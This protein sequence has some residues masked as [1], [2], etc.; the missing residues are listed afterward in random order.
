MTQSLLGLMKPRHTAGTSLARRA[1][2]TQDPFVGAV[3]HV[4]RLKVLYKQIKLAA[5]VCIRPGKSNQVYL[6][7]Y[8]LALLFSNLLGIS[9]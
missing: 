6:W 9:N 7:I 2:H 1:N 8:A 3:R 4:F 5:T